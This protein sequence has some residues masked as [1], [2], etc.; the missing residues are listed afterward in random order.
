M[1]PGGDLGWG[2]LT[3]VE[4]R[5]SAGVRSLFG[6]V[7]SWEE[8]LVLVTGSVSSLF[9]ESSDSSSSPSPDTPE[10][11]ELDVCP[12]SARVLRGA[13]RSGVPLSAL[14][15]PFSAESLSITSDAISQASPVARSQRRLQPNVQKAGRTELKRFSN[16]VQLRLRV[17]LSLTALSCKQKRQI[18]HSIRISPFSPQKCQERENQEVKRRVLGLHKPFFAGF[19]SVSCFASSEAQ[20]LPANCNASGY[21]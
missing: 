6:V 21:I 17:L 5:A 11:E 13:T 19:L 4:L 20:Y 18:L 16:F 3:G 15:S 14:I 7:L 9:C 10:D 12:C 1:G 8:S 2:R